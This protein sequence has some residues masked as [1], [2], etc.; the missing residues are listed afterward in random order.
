MHQENAAPD[1]PGGVAKDSQFNAFTL[2]AIGALACI[3]A[4][5]V[6]EAVG[7][8]TA[9]LLMSNPIQ[10]LS[11]VAIQNTSANV[12]NRMTTR[13]GA[14]DGCS[15]PRIALPAT[16]VG[17]AYFVVKRCQGFGEMR[18]S[19]IGGRRARLI[20]YR[21]PSSSTNCQPRQ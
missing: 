10:S 19:R 8:G 7:H 14:F 12:E 5:M 21:S 6:H 16:R 18:L 9:S 20:S 3:A 2:V 17:A 4:D 1:T 11:T 15:D 13:D